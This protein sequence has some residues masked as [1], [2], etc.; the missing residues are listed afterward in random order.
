MAGSCEC[1]NE[2]SGSLNTGNFSTS[3]EPVS[4]SRRSC[5]MELVSLFVGCMTNVHRP[6]VFLMS[7]CQKLFLNFKSVY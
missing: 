7:T 2:I 4:L 6:Y 1:G 3:Y 5:S